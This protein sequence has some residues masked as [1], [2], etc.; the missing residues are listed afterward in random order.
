VN[1]DRWR[2][3]ET[4]YN[5]ARDRGL[6]VLADADPELR[7]EVERL[8]EQHSGGG[9]LD[10]P[11]AQ[12]LGELP[13]V[14]TQLGSVSPGQIFSHYRIER[15]LGGGGMGIVYLAQDLDLGRKVALKF[16]PERMAQDSDALER[17]RREA[18]TASSLN[19]PNICTI[20]EIGTEGSRS[21]IVMEHLEGTT[22]KHFVEAG[23]LPTETI[24]SLGIEIT[25]ALDAAHAAGIIHRDIKPA[26]IFVTARGHAKLLDFGLAKFTLAPDVRSGPL[27]GRTHTMPVELTAAGSVMG[28][29]SHMSPEQVRGESLDYRTD[30]FSLG[31]VFYEMAT[32]AL[33]FP[34]THP[35]VVFDCILNREPTAPLALNPSLAPEMQHIIQKCLEKDR[36]RRYQHA[37]EIAR[38]LAVLSRAPMP[39]SAPARG[40]W[41]IAAAALVLALAMGTYGYFHRSPRVI[42]KSSLVLADF[43]NTTG[44]PSLGQAL[45]QRLSLELAQSPSITLVTEV[46]IRQL[47]KLMLRPDDPR[48][49]PE[50][51]REV[52]ERDGASAVVEGSIS[53][54]GSQYVLGLRAR[55]CYSGEVLDEEQMT[56]ARKEDVV[57]SLKQAV[58]RF[59]SR[60]A[61][62]LP[63]LE[64][65]APL[66]DATTP[67]LEALKA[68]TTGLRQESTTSDSSAVEHYRRA[69]A[70]D[71]EFAT[72]YAWLAQE[73]YNLDQNE[74]AAEYMSKAYQLRDRGSDREKF[75]ISYGYDRNLTGN[76]EKAARTLES[77]EQTYPRDAFAHSLMAGRVTV[78]T[79][80]YEESIQEAQASIAL[81]PQDWHGYFSLAESSIFMGRLAD[82]ADAVRRA[83]GNKLDPAG[84]HH[85]LYYIAFLRGN[86]AEMARQGALLQQRRNSRD[87]FL[88]AESMVLA[89]SG[90]LREAG[91]GWQRAIDLATDTGDRERAA[92]YQT[93]AAVSEA[94]E[95]DVVEARRRAHAALDL[96]KGRDVL[97]A[98]AVAFALCG[99]SAL[100]RDLANQM[101]RR[102]PEDTIVQHQYLPTLRALDALGA[103]NPKTALEEL[104][105]ARPYDLAQPGTAINGRF[106]GLYLVDVRGMAY[107][108]S[109]QLAQA[110]AEFQTILQHRAVALAD[111][112]TSLAHLQLARAF[113]QAGEVVK[114]KAAYAEFLKVWERADRDLRPLREAQAEL[115]ALK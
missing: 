75:L 53:S 21:F 49:T 69:I 59:R 23:P 36:T 101:A 104:E 96:S 26:N 2:Q 93:A 41:A 20:H 25:E 74:K 77:W 112:V 15:K 107:L 14:E 115:A 76:L 18:R 103:G 1:P 54:L 110:A 5:A 73:Y 102:F 51:G 84:L 71:P 108:A 24:A 45:R 7:R 109:H 8:L 89:Y 29:V 3:V 106:G 56:A 16:L 19:H 87:G 42:S 70:L 85:L 114:A 95:G 43:E 17:F 99:D 81:D 94:R 79:G 64:R 13:S 55:N 58:A 27:T 47:M 86:E 72:A 66:E 100:P 113:V 10:R 9:F 111:P 92:V 88:N 50:V 4:L 90:R 78:C 46:R 91:F 39:P 98:A 62:S 48:L 61:E 6:S 32:S 60:L 80:H 68:L 11:A 105:P 65:H 30:L 40:R 37:S 34:G 97:Y 83:A 82:A 35:S 38:D 44:D 67:S 12:F 57:D 33:P 63:A 31:V 28:T 52:C 22:L